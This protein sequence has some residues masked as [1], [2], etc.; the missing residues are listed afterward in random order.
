MRAALTW[1]SHP[2]HSTVGG[3]RD[4]GLSHVLLRIRIPVKQTIKSQSLGDRIQ[5]TETRDQ[6]ILIKEEELVKSSYHAYH[7]CKVESKRSKR[8]RMTTDQMSVVVAVLPSLA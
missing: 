5:A 2:L 7:R 8:P 6:G 1:K 3:F 4:D